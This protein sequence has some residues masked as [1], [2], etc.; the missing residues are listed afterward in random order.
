M[1]L[2]KFDPNASSYGETYKLESFVVIL[3][4]TFM[5]I[6]ISRAALSLQFD[7]VSAASGNPL[8]RYTF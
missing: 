6:A 1:S 5:A 7:S 2:C 3:M 8:R 4:L